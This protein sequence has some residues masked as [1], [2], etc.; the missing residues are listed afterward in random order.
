ML[1]GRCIPLLL[2]L[3]LLGCADASPADLD[4]GPPDSGELTDRGGCRGDT[5]CAANQV[6]VAGACRTRCA[7]DADCPAKG[8]I[9]VASACNR[10]FKITGTRDLISK[11]TFTPIPEHTG[12]PAKDLSVSWEFG[13]GGSKGYQAPGPVTHQFLTVGTHKVTV[14][15][16]DRTAKVAPSSASYSIAI[17]HPNYWPRIIPTYYMG[18]F[19]NKPVNDLIAKPGNV[20]AVMVAAFDL[21][22]TATKKVN[23]TLL[24]SIHGAGL[25]AYLDVA[26]W[27]APWTDWDKMSAIMSTLVSSGLDGMDFDEYGGKGSSIDA[28]KFNKLRATLKA[29]NPYFRMIITQIQYSEVNALLTAGAKPDYIALEWYLAGKTRFDE[30]KALA[31]KYGVRLAYWVDP[32]TFARIQKTYKEASAVMLWNLCWAQSTCG[33]QYPYKSWLPWAD[34]LPF[35]EK[36][37]SGLEASP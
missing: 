15:F 20:R 21:Y 6:C 3:L 31:A 36:L 22:N 12:I 27:N 24:D 29:I 11:L 30:A 1:D 32:T 10:Y 5:G 8:D 18:G 34:V 13:S 35:L 9:C 14:T 17:S 4:G 26:Q 19:T 33:T 2:S 37:G 16:K 25:L 23:T 7:T 28:T